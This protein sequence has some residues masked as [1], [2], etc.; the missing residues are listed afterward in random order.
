MRSILGSAAAL[1]FALAAAGLACGDGDDGPDTVGGRDAA[2]EVGQPIL[3]TSPEDCN[4]GDECT[5]DS[6][7]AAGVCQHTPRVGTQPLYTACTK[8]CDCDTGWCYDQAYMHP[9]RF[10]TKECGG[11]SVGCGPDA[12]NVCGLLSGPWTQTLDPPV[13]VG[14][15]CL[16]VCGTAADCQALDPAWE[17]CTDGQTVMTDPQGDTHTITLRKTCF[18]TG[19]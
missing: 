13:T 17:G 8:H 15:F 1:I 12:E 7:S 3:C 14:A 6:C 9:F 16:P 19:D 11:V 4:D 2:G 5:D 10:C 18:A